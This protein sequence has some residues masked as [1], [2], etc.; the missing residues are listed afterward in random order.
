MICIRVTAFLL[1]VACACETR[2]ALSQLA[3]NHLIGPL[4]V[5]EDS[6]YQKENSMIY[7]GAKSIT[8]IGATWTPETARLL[9]EEIK[10]ITTKPIGEVINT[11]YHPDRA[12]GNAYWR[13][14]G[15]KIVSTQ[16][17]YDL[18]KRAW[19]SLVDSTRKGFPTYTN[20]PPALPSVTYASDFELQDGRVR[21]FYLGPSHTLDG[22]F[23]YFPEEKVLYG[24][25]ILKEQIG[26]LA[27]ADRAEY[28]KT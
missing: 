18:M 12:G 17:T 13:D 6:Y 1:L 14:V 5:V 7:V 25:C 28:P 23:V 27:F 4:Y 11:N 22:I 3:L 8:I 21:A 2:G 15:A 19:S 9:H 16:M 10:K 20:L 26:N 24:G